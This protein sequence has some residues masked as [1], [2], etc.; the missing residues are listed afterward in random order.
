M[1]KHKSP[2]DLNTRLL[3]V[4]LDTYL[5]VK[6]I[7]RRLRINMADALTKL[8]TGHIPEAE[9]VS[10][11]VH[12]AQISMPVTM[13]KAMPVTAAYRS[14][15]VVSIT[16]NGHSSVAFRIKPKGVRHD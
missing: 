12:P 1:K 4:H 7:S 11:P 13:A 15:P 3:R 14:I 10:Q 6:G 2:S 5:V 16:T 9:P 8:I